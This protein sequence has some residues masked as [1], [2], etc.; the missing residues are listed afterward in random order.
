MLRNNTIKLNSSSGSAVLSS[1]E[2]FF[3]VH[4][5][6][7]SAL[8][9]SHK[10]DYVLSCCRMFSLLRSHLRKKMKTCILSAYGLTFKL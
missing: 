9:L 3:S 2:Q 7:V 8:M 6:A 1:L 10:T 5:K 4:S